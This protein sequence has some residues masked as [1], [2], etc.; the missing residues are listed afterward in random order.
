MP[1]RSESEVMA[2]SSHLSCPIMVLR[3]DQDT[4]LSPPPPAA[5]GGGPLDPVLT[6]PGQLPALLQGWSKMSS[7]Q[8]VSFVTI[9]GSHSYWEEDRGRV[10]LLTKM[11]QASSKQ[12]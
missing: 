7:S 4:T 12:H 10:T 2:R 6:R 8:P 5:T 9:P 1:Y 11:A 3:G